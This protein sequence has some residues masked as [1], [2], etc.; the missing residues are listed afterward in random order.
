MPLQDR[1]YPQSP[2]LARV[3]RGNLCAGC[4]ACAGLAPDK[5]AMQVTA[6]GYLRPQQ[7]AALTAPEEEAIART[8]PGLGQAVVAA[9]RPDSVLWG[10]CISMQ[11]G[12][13]TDPAVR[14]AGSSGGALSMLLVHLLAS[15][16]SRQ[17]PLTR[18]SLPP[19]SPDSASGGARSGPGWP[20]CVWRA[21]RSPAMR[22]CRSSRQ[23]GKTPGPAI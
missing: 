7:S 14:F 19:S 8:C 10:P 13:A 1:K 23:P 3:A 15:G 16:V 9:G 5:I 18:A 12:W 6:P 20:P 2:A 21:A 4:G 22:V 17:Q 11:T